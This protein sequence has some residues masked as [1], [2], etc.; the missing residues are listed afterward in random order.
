VQATKQLM[1]DEIGGGNPALMAE[2]Q[3][4]VFS[5]EDA[6][7]GSIAFAQKRAPEWKGR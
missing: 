4:V 1:L 3:K 5:S 6:K 7:E 2:L